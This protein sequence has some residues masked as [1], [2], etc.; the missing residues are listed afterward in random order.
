[1]S[2][3]R[4]LAFSFFSL[5]GSVLSSADFTVCSYN[6]GG[7]SSH[8]DYLRTAA[9][10]NIMQKRHVAE[11]KEMEL[12]DTIQKVFLKILFAPEG[13]EKEAALTEWYQKEYQRK[14]LALAA[15]P[16]E[17]DSPNKKW[18]DLVEMT[19]TAYKER[20]VQIYDPEVQAM[21]DDHL[22]DISGDKS[23][24]KTRQIMAKRIF[25]RELK[26][27]IICLQ[28]ADYLDSAI[29]PSHYEVMFSDE[30]HS[31]NGIAFNSKRFVV[32]AEIGD[33]SRF[34]ALQLRERESGKIFLV[35]SGHLTGCNPYYVNVNLAGTP[36][37]LK[38]DD[39]LN[40][41][42]LHFER[43]P[44]TDCIIIGMDSNVTSLHPRMGILREENYQLDY[45]NH[46]DP[47]CANP[48]QV[49][50][51]RIDWI[52]VKPMEKLETTIT[53]IP[54]LNVHLNCIQTNISDHKPVAARI[55]F[56]Y[57][58]TVENESD[59]VAEEEIGE[60][61]NPIKKDAADLIEEKKEAEEFL[62]E[63][64]R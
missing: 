10:Q 19:I 7:L 30:S 53:N 50:N 52:V 24:K 46:L 39:E 28:E 31:K 45:E 49:L 55:S 64:M 37:S 26:F 36:D 12:N 27:D 54:V 34:Y 1:M 56:E 57:D 59:E 16:T 58:V 3:L 4:L 40:S 29:F 61:E 18:R 25:A 5:S 8:Y 9:M 42:I 2:S 32:H 60:I 11:P 63:E 38:G 48:H 20:P 41:G 13:E 33:Y 62:S 47:S 23:V 14:I 6:C 15:F 17:K 22:K 21:L 43:Y 44:S 35:V 51:T